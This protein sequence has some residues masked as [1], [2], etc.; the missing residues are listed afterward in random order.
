MRPH[1]L[2]IVGVL[3]R[4]LPFPYGLLAERA[5]ELRHNV[6]A[7]DAWYVALAEGLEAGLATLDV[8]LSLASGP[9]CAFVTPT[10]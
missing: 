6:T 3:A 5:W 2:F 10:G 9:R 8:R 7:Y 4:P 1:L